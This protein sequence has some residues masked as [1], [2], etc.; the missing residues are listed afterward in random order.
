MGSQFK[1]VATEYVFPKHPCQIE[2]S[3]ADIS[4][5]IKKDVWQDPYN[6]FIDKLQGVPEATF[7]IHES[8]TKIYRWEY[9]TALTLGTGYWTVVHW[10][11][12][13]LDSKLRET[14]R[15]L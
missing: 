1:R 6:N 10:E 5:F 4:L 9:D 7:L 12:A 2:I 8:I 3:G 11:V 13:M 14:I 15:N